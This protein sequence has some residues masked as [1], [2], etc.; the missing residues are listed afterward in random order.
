MIKDIGGGMSMNDFNIFITPGVAC[1]IMVV[2]G[3][4]LF[5]IAVFID[6]KKVNGFRQPDMK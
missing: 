1:V 6:Y 4:I 2:E 5:H 3:F